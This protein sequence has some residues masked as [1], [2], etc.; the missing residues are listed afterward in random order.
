MVLTCQKVKVGY[1]Q[2]DTET[3]LKIQLKNKHVPAKPNSA[4]LL[5]DKIQSSGNL[6]LLC[7]VGR[8]KLSPR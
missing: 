5:L 3:V 2:L 1:I 7:R 6:F 4:D 8:D